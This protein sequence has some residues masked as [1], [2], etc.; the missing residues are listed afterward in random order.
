MRKT[1]E[2]VKCG[3][4]LIFGAMLF[5]PLIGYFLEPFSEIDSEE[6]RRLALFPSA[7]DPS[8]FIEQTD[9]YI[10]D[11]F[12]FR[13]ELIQLN[14]VIEGFDRADVQGF[15][16]TGREGWSYYVGD[17][18][19]DELKRDSYLSD[20][21]V[22]N[23]STT[24]RQRA[25]AC[26]RKGISYLFVVVPDKQSVYPEF[27]PPGYLNANRPSRLDKVCEVVGRDPYLSQHFL[28][29]SPVMRQNENQKVTSYFKTD[30]HWNALGAYYGYQAVMARFKAL[31]VPVSSVKFSQFTTVSGFSGDLNGFSGV[32]NLA[33]PK[34]EYVQFPGHEE[35]VAL[36]GFW[37]PG[38][39]ET[40]LQGWQS[41]YVAV[42]PIAPEQKSALVLCDSFGDLLVDYLGQTFQ[43]VIVVHGRDSATLED[44]IK[45]VHPDV[46]ID[47]I[48]QRLLNVE[49]DEEVRKVRLD[50]AVSPLERALTVLSDPRFVLR[51]DASG[52]EELRFG[53]SGAPFGRVAG[54]SA[55]SVEQI[56][57]PYEGADIAYLDGWAVSS[58]TNKPFDIIV[59]TLGSQL[60][61]LDTGDRD[62]P[63]L[64]GSVS[65]SKCGF[66]IQL[67]ERLLC[68]P[69]QIRIFG[70]VL[71][72]HESEVAR[73]E[74]VPTA[75]APS[76]L[77]LSLRISP[78]S[79]LL[80]PSKLEIKEGKI[81]VIPGN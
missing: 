19:L 53:D 23:L 58:L 67:S 55:G 59:V 22:L 37:R 63:E 13:N 57:Q 66:R 60:L 51:Q 56:S 65:G 42:N 41:S 79:F 38:E 25:E 28:S 5:A 4:A 72:S 27:L 35:K 2:Y 69:G 64:G 44:T 80:P 1:E 73:L 24:V 52:S 39:R 48:V 18:G 32:L 70:L 71:P 33:Q 81:Q 46:V 76:R 61:T 50:G 21:E 10:N 54:T 62:R 11:H 15:L 43:K 12:G 17:S 45:R 40:K 20:G 7:R 47:E 36:S 77:K 75:E 3:F 74:E 34:D 14:H 29:L 8:L 30:S 49:W 16:L 78:A 6:N 26:D 31:G 9:S 68:R